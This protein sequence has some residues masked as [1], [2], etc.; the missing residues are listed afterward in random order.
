MARPVRSKGGLRFV[1]KTYDQ[2]LAE[3]IADWQSNSGITDFQPG[4]LT[5]T[6]LAV[7]ARALRTLW[8]ML[9]QLINL[10]FVSSST[11]SFLIRRAAERGVIQKLGTAAQGNIDL[12]RSTA[13]PVGSTMTKGTVLATL[14]DA[15]EFTVNADVTLAAGWTSATAALTCTTVGAAGNLAAGTPLKIV[16]SQVVGVQNI[17]V[18]T[19]GLSGGTDD[20]TP[21]QLRARYL[22]TIQNPINGGTPADYVVWAT[23]VAGVKQAIPLP[24]NRGPGTID[25]VITD[26]GIPSD[27]LVTDVTNYIQDNRRPVGADV[28]V[29]KPTAHPIG[30][31]GTITAAQ[32][33]VQSDLVT[34]VTQ[35]LEAYIAGVP[36]G[37][38]VRYNAMIKVAMEVK[39]VLDFAM[40][41]PTA[42]VVLGSTELATVG[43]VT[44]S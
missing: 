24:L 11:G 10:F 42:N 17:T 8:F 18:A 28:L 39:G 29:L 22:Y 33:Y 36:I 2:I 15:I 5:Y 31:T 7:Q 25:V 38:V 44:I 41:A 16:G 27:S 20:E 21:D 13:A 9:E 40:T 35:A 26:G 1:F 43:A 23:S 34:A 6:F 3:L 19:G 14:D 30:I 32:G 37:G 4:A 12:T